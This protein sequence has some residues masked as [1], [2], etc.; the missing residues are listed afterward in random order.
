ML[1]W[2]LEVTEPERLV[3]L[4]ACCARSNLIHIASVPIALAQVGSAHTRTKREDDA[5][6]GAI[7]A[8]AGKQHEALGAE[9]YTLKHHG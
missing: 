1:A 6:E 8:V 5:A 4:L 3:N 9:G 2:V 7:G